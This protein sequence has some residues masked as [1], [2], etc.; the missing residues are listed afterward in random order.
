MF[1]TTEAEQYAGVHTTYRFHSWAG[2]AGSFDPQ[3]KAA[4]EDHEDVDFVEPDY[5][6]GPYSTHCAF[7]INNYK[8]LHLWNG[9]T[10][11]RSELGVG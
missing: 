7:L 3:T 9:N 10:N 2:Y 5:K 4:I 1:S 11:R 6:V 8:G